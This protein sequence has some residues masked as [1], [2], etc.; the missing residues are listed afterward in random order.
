MKVLLIEDDV[1]TGKS[2]ESMLRSLGH[3]C[4]WV[5][6]GESGVACATR[7]GYDVILLD[8]MLPDIDGYEVLQ[9]L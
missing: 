8:F 4:H 3:D 9:K 5:E 2:V 1:Q 7:E 6:E